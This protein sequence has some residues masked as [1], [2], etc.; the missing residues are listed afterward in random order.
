[1]A[2]GKNHLCPIMVN[3]ETALWIATLGNPLFG[4]A[5]PQQPRGPVRSEV[6]LFCSPYD[7]GQAYPT[8]GGTRH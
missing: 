2:F 1:M 4:I 3:A 6:G 7:W 8:A 5:C